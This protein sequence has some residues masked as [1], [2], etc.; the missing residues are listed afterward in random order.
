MFVAL[1]LDLA[2]PLV[3]A[4]VGLCLLIY[5]FKKPGDSRPEVESGW[6]SQVEL[7]GLANVALAVETPP[8]IVREAVDPVELAIGC[9]VCGSRLGSS[10]PRR[11]LEVLWCEHCFQCFAT[12]KKKR[13]ADPRWFR[14]CLER[15]R[16]DLRRHRLFGTA[17]T[18]PAAEYFVI[19]ECVACGGTGRHVERTCHACEGS[20]RKRFFP[21]Q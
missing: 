17:M 2:I 18:D 19:V 3:M 16:E 9:W 4:F 7:V 8:A 15:F 1:V 14:Y 10:N 21:F 13:P 11:Y 5:F 6:S 20:G 12:R